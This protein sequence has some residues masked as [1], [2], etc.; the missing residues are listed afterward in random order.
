[1]LGVGFFDHAV[2]GDRLPITR[3]AAAAVIFGFAVEQVLPAAHA[4]VGARLRAMRKGAGM[5]RF[6]A[7]A[8]AHG[9]LLGRQLFLPFLAGFDEFFSHFLILS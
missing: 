3:P 2:L 9:I 1:M 8:T 5:R 7:A 6:G 4:S